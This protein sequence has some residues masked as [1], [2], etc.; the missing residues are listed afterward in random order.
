MGRLDLTDCEWDGIWL[1]REDQR[2][3]RIVSFRAASPRGGGLQPEQHPVAGNYRPGSEIVWPTS[4]ESSLTRSGIAQNNS[5]SSSSSLH[6]WRG[7]TQNMR[8]LGRC[9]VVHIA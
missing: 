4:F 3:D 5:R 8:F 7:R 2:P 6:Q 9:L 1:L